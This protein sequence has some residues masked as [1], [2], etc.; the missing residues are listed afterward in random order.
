[1]KKIWVKPE[2]VILVRNQPEESVLQA[3]KSNWH[4]VKGP[5]MA[6]DM[7]LDFMSSINCNSLADS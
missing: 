4:A 5:E 6:Y 1:M 7:C 2:L 3:C